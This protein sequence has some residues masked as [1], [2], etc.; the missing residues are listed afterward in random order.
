MGRTKAVAVDPLESAELDPR[1][2]DVKP[3]W[4]EKCRTITKH[5]YTHKSRLYSGCLGVNYCCVPCGTSRRY[6]VE[7]PTD[8]EDPR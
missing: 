7:G 1:N 2:L 3:L 5:I 6:G 4:C 8:S